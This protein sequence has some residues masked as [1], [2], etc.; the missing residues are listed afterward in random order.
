M[1]ISS[2]ADPETVRGVV[3]SWSDEH[4]WGF[5]RTTCSGQSSAYSSELTIEYDEPS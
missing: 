4:G 1:T 3:R 5:S 2:A